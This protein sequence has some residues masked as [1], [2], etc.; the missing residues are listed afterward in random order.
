LHH[1]FSA[2]TPTGAAAIVRRNSGLG[3]G[4]GLGSRQA[5]GIHNTP[6]TPLIGDYIRAASFVNWLYADA[7]P[8]GCRHKSKSNATTN[9]K[10]TPRRVDRTGRGFTNISAEAAHV[11]TVTILEPFIPFKAVPESKSLSSLTAPADISESKPKP[12]P[13]AISSPKSPSRLGKVQVHIGSKATLSLSN[14][15]RQSK[16]HFGADETH[17]KE[18]KK[19][20]TAN[21][22]LAAKSAVT[23]PVPVM[24]PQQ[25]SADRPPHDTVT[26]TTSTTSLSSTPAPPAAPAPGKNPLKR[27][28]ELALSDS[29]PV[30]A[31]SLALS[32]SMPNSSRSTATTASKRAAGASGGTGGGGGL[33]TSKLQAAARSLETAYE[34]SSDVFEISDDGQEE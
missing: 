5:S 3:L 9:T 31:R 23:H 13:A 21:H 6:K 12:P 19:P 29:K 30:S 25:Q 4:F 18:E 10:N 32:E 1:A 7:T 11:A 24:M 2:A 26:T 27:I 34:T 15:S 20:T 28:T 22:V 14:E 16:S 33:T 8:L 17:D